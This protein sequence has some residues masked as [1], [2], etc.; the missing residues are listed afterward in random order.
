MLSCKSLQ[1]DFMSVQTRSKEI[2]SKI[3]FL[4]YSVVCVVITFVHI[5]RIQWDDI[6]NLVKK[7]KQVQ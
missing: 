7:T 2:K 6:G 5:T 3:K 4:M 1:S